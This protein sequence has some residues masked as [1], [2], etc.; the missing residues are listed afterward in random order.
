MFMPCLCSA[1][2]R[3]PRQFTTSSYFNMDGSNE[4]PVNSSQYWVTPE[5]WWPG[6]GGPTVS[7]VFQGW[8]IRLPWPLILV[9]VVGR[10]ASCD[11]Q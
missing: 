10:C 2:V 4:P 3:K 9:A 7:P 11:T 6:I 1:N 8:V 5:L